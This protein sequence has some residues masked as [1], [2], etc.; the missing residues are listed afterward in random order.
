VLEDLKASLP[1][2]MPPIEQVNHLLPLDLLP[3]LAF[4]APFSPNALGKVGVRDDGSGKF[5]RAN[6]P[7]L[8]DWLSLNIPVQ[9]GKAAVRLEEANGTVNVHFADGSRATGDIVVGADGVHSIGKSK[10]KRV[11]CGDRYLRSR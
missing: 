7:V 11:L 3:E 8:W 5:I 9:Y 1:D 4:Y 10:P 6:R 2:D